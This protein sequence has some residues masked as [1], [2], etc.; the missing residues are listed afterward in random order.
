[1]KSQLKKLSTLIICCGIIA[2]LGVPNIAEAQ[3]LRHGGGTS[4]GSRPAA[5]RPAGNRTI[6]GGAHRSPSR[7]TNLQQRNYSNNRNRTNNNFSNQGNRNNNVRTNNS[8][9]NNTRVSNIKSNNRTGSN[10][11]I[12]IDNSTNINV[13]RNVRRNVNRRSTVVIRNP[14]PYHRPPYRYGGFSFYCYHPYYYHPF[15]P[16]YWGPVW[17]PWGFFVA[18]LAATAIVISIENEK[19]HYDQGV[20]YQES[21]G[22]YTVVEAPSG[23]TVKTIPG[24]SEQVIINETTNNYYY[25]GT[26]Y[27]KSEDGYTVVPPTSGS[28]V[29]NLPDGA[30]EV[31][32]GDQTYVKYGETYYQPVQVEGKNKY[33]VADVQDADQ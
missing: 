29:T 30:E 3:R 23:A 13:N 25:G 33:E 31:K 24:D 16:Y 8:R 18:S 32:V 28:V 9:N 7:P 22:G 6:N 11:R 2:M 26:Y 15:V 14:R 5:A 1:M 17:H 27:E 19:Y 20:F 12:N 21:N 10:N 4:R